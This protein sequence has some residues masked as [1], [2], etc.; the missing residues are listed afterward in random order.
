VCVR[1]PLPGDTNQASLVI[2][3]L[4]KGGQPRKT[5]VKGD[6]AMMSPNGKLLAVKGPKKYFINICFILYH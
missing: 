4:E 6:A 3:D 1:E 2:V 5:G